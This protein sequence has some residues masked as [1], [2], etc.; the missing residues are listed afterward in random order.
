MVVRTVALSGLALG[1]LLSL[2]AC[3]GDAGGTPGGDPSTWAWA[4]AS[5]P[6]IL[7]LSHAADPYGNGEMYLLANDGTITPVVDGTHANANPS[8]TDDGSRVAFHRYTTPGDFSSLDLFM[9]DISTGEETRLTDD[10]FPAAAPKW[11]PDGTRLLY[12]SWRTYDTSSAANVF[13][14]DLSDWSV[15]EV[16]TDPDHEDNDPSWCGDDAIAFKSTRGTD[17][18]YQERIF[19]VDLDGS[20]VRQLST[21]TGWESDHDPRCSPDGEWVYFYRYE[22]TRPWVEQTA[23]NWNEVYPVNVWRVNRDGQQEQLTDCEFFCAG[24]IPGDDGQVAYVEKQFL[25][26]DAGDLIG[27]TARLMIM[28]A[29]GSNPRE[30]LPPSV[31]AAHASTLDWFD[32]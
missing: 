2:A 17:V 14:L 31:Y 3:S 26:D 6:R 9:V 22:A 1:S 4:N 28:D 15:T 12:S 29:D 19:L 10:A 21:T 27:T 13:I 32:W 11:N 16:T 25:L 18:A 7:L 24:P 8:I 20:N 23:K 5:N 30:L